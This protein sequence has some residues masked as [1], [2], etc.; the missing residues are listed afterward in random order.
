MKVLL[1][2]PY[3]GAGY[4]YRPDE[5]PY[6][7]RVLEDMRRDG[8]FD[9]IDVAI[10]AGAVSAHPATSRDDDVFEHIGVATLDRIKRLAAEGAADAIVVLGGI[11]VAFHAMRV[12]CPIPVVHFVHASLHVASL[13]AD[14]FSLVDLTD[15]QAARARRLARTYG[16]DDK[17]VT[18]RTLGASSTQLSTL[19]RLDDP[20]ADP[21]VGQTLDTLVEVCGV[22]VDVDGADLL[23]LTFTPLQRLRDE[24]R[25]R[26]DDAGYA[27]IPVVW[28]LSAAVA[29]ARAMVDLRLLPA[30][31]SYPRDDL[32]LEPAV[33]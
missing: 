30:P 24:V 8:E 20:L 23:I 18:I 13:V 9:G 10:D 31:R 3:R 26:L 32:R 15:P 16:F 27:E 21:T 4:D 5:E 29:V 19:L 7:Q 6:Y 2:P 28:S 14:R 22:A 17:L 25:R 33:R 1:V 12:S 11:D